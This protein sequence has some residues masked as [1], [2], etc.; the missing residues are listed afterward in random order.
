MFGGWYD[1]SPAPARG[2]EISTSIEDLTLYADVTIAKSRVFMGFWAFGGLGGEMGRRTSPLLDMIHLLLCTNTQHYY[3][4]GP[5]NIQVTTAACTP[6]FFHSHSYPPLSIA[7]RR[8]E[9]AHWRKKV[10]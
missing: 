5:C 10:A 4:A 3:L 9:S 8:L 1:E 7:F 2:N 6:R